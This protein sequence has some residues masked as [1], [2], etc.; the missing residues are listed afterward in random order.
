MLVLGRDDVDV[1]G[2][3]RKPVAR[4]DDRHAGGAGQEIGQPA[5]V[6]GIEVLHE[7]EGHPGLRRQI[8]QEL[9]EGLQAPGGSADPDDG[10]RAFGRLLGRRIQRRVGFGW[11]IHRHRHEYSKNEKRLCDEEAYGA[12]RELSKTPCA[13]ETRGQATTMPV[14]EIPQ[15]VPVARPAARGVWRRDVRFAL[16]NDADRRAVIRLRRPRPMAA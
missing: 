8:G 6:A 14:T 10:K 2:F 11:L 12:A 4:L 5:L 15:T 16:E 9:G 13:C 7:H 3:D 1:I